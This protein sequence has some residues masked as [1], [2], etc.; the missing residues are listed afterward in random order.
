VPIELWSIIASFT[1]RRTLAC[2]CSVSHLFYSIFSPLLYANIIKPLLNNERS[3][4]IVRTLCDR[5]A[6]M[7]SWKPQPAFLIQQLAL[8]GAEFHK[9]ETAMMAVTALKSM[10]SLRSPVERTRGATLRVLR[11]NLPAGVDELGKVL[12]APEHF[13]NLRELTVFCDGKNTNFTVRAIGGSFADSANKFVHSSFKLE[14]LRFLD[15]FWTLTTSP[16]SVTS[17]I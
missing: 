16:V 14:A 2:L 8:G 5:D 13:P 11:W 7:S 6:Q 4:L 17:L 9:P 15:S 12:G 3:T 10:Y 1:S